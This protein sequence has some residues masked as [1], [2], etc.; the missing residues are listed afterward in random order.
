VRATGKRKTLGGAS[1]GEG[2][3]ATTFV[4]VTGGRW[5][6][7]EHGVGDPD[8]NT[9]DIEHFVLDL[10]TGKKASVNETLPYGEDGIENVALPS[11][12][13]GTGGGVTANYINGSSV[14]LSED[15]TAA[16]LAV[17]GSRLYW[18]TGDVAHTALL[19]V[20]KRDPMRK[21]PAATK[22]GRCKPRNG[23]RLELWA[24]KRIVLTR[25]GGKVW[26]CDSGRGTTRQVGKVTGLAV[27]SDHQLTYLRDGM[28]ST[29]DVTT[30]ARTEVAGTAFAAN[31]KHLLVVATD[32]LRNPVDVLAA[33]PATEPA[34]AG[35]Y[36]YWLDGTGAPQVKLLARTRNPA[37]SPQPLQ[38]T[39]WSGR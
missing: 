10:R 24:L 9:S 5:V 31:D 1:S 28:V 34:L 11:V 23:A 3:E 38:A 20:A 39:R 32:G 6:W 13:V 19:D 36:A 26:A 27:T 12:I 35:D 37:V 8:A 25:Q 14:K 2:S 22:I 17:A 33:A 30:G 16:D 15:P 18:R 7:L 4:G 21:G 29:L